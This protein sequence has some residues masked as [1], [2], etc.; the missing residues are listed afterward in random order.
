MS[1]SKTPRQRYEEK[2]MPLGPARPECVGWNAKIDK[3]D[4]AQFSYTARDGAK[5]SINAARWAWVEFRGE[6]P[7]H[8]K[9]S[10]LC[11]L[12]SC[13]NLDHWHLKPSNTDKTLWE[14]YELKFTKGGPDECWPWQDK[15]RDKDDYGIF[16]YRDKEGK[17]NVTV[18]AARWGWEQLNGPLK[19]G[20]VVCHTCDNPPCQ[21]PAHWFSGT[22]KVNNND[23]MAKGRHRVHSGETHGN[24]K[25]T[26]AQVREIRRLYATGDWTHQALADRY[27]VARRTISHIISGNRWKEDDHG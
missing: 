7:P 23:K 20:E 11:G 2:L 21:N 22:V 25:M 4:N 14:Q 19:D 16:S 15:S 17:K 13:Q 10:N 27:G 9:V 24:A 12:K 1:T 3:Y 8:H 26:W 5:K 18:R 6:I